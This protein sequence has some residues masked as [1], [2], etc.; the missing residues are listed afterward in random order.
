[1]SAPPGGW[2]A[3]TFKSVGSPTV[4]PTG[5]G[6]FLV[7]EEPTKPM[8]PSGQRKWIYLT[9]DGGDTWSGPIPTP[10]GPSMLGFGPYFTDKAGWLASGASAWFS[11]D[12]GATWTTTGSLPR[13]WEFGIIAPVGQETAWAQGV[14]SSA[15]DVNGTLTSSWG[16]FQT[17]DRG[18]H[19][20]RVQVP[21]AI[22]SH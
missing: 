2:L 3:D 7:Y 21:P 18:R 11:S 8:P 9:Q 12:L 10:V 20:R 5:L 19:W 17:T 4:L 1:V 14:E 6:T 22:S 13:G 15:P 16:L